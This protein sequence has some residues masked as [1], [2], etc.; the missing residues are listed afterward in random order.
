VALLGVPT[1]S[2]EIDVAA[3]AVRDITIKG[4]LNG[5]GQY[6]HGLAAIE[7]GAVRPELLIDRV[8]P[9]DDVAAALARSREPGRLRPKV[10]VA[11]EAYASEA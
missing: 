10:L 7:S 4:V 2:V 1:S 11:L 5:P 6:P 3:V 9:F 8:Y